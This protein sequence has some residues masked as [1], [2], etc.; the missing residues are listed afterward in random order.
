MSLAERLD[1]P[2]SRRGSRCSVGVLLG[3]LE[4]TERDALTSMLND[5]IRWS[6]PGIWDA[7]NDE[8]YEASVTMIE[9]HRRRGCRCSKESDNG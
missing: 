5:R 2:P 7:L 9:R 6:A 3:R 8:G 4:D 1:N